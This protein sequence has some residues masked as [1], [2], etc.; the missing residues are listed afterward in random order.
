MLNP[1]DVI[2]RKTCDAA[3]EQYDAFDT[4][5]NIIGYL[6]LRWGHFTVEVPDIGGALVYEA[7]CS[8]QS[9]FLDNERLQCL[10]DARIAIS[11]YYS[12][13]SIKDF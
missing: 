5:G 11:S 7:I 9:V 4:F 8:G 13:S 6:R 12:G 10:Q 2:I 3:P 1:E